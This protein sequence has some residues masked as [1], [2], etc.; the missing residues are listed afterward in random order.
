MAKIQVVKHKNI[1]V[2]HT[3]HEIYVENYTFKAKIH[4]MH[5]GSNN[6]VSESFVHK[7]FVVFNYEC[8]EIRLAFRV[9]CGLVPDLL[10]KDS[11]HSVFKH[12]IL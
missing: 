3:K 9:I 4:K 2:C 6:H 12:Q 7:K 10:L 8:S 5:T 11:I 1:K